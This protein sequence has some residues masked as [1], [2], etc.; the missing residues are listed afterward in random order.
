MQE[1]TKI[2][3]LL[4]EEYKTYPSCQITPEGLGKIAERLDRR[5]SYEQVER[6]M[7]RLSYK[8][9]FFPSLAEIVENIEKPSVYCKPDGERIQFVN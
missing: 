6:A 1:V 3:E 5:Y 7:N 9:R 4:V 2:Y 8:A